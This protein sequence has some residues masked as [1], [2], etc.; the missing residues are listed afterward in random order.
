MGQTDQLQPSISTLSEIERTKFENV[1]YRT[2]P[3]LSFE[4]RKTENFYHVIERASK[5]LKS[6]EI[7]VPDVLDSHHELIFRCL[8]LISSQ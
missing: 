8:L 2:E 5:I 7:Y 6:L 1:S 4:A 3:E